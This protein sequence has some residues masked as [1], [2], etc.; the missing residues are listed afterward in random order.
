MASALRTPSGAFY[1]DLA[2]PLAY[3]ASER[4]LQVL[5]SE[6]AVVQWR[7]VLATGLPAGETFE[8]FRC[9]TEAD[10]FRA[11]VERRAR[12]LHLPP[13]RW[14]EQFPFDSS[15]AMR[16]ATF[17]A[18]IGRALPFAQA[19]F[20]QAFAGG[21]SLAETDNILIAAA[22]CEMHPRAVLA[23]IERE[24]LGQELDAA[25]RGAARAGVRDVPA[26]VIERPGAA[27]L[28]LHGERELDR[29]GAL[30]RGEPTGARAQEA[31]A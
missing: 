15:A 13:L 25:T 22:A 1:F 8:A 5:T 23:A 28:V 9:G 26:V 31:Q 12:E 10:V 2:S 14:P 27:A 7:G 4:A 30:L 3:L 6:R 17:A 18:S 11:E 29:A 20:R 21:R 16:V 19:A 24:S